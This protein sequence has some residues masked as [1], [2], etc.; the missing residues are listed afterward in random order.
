MK[1]QIV[2]LLIALF[3][4][5]YDIYSYLNYKKDL[6]KQY[7]MIHLGDEDTGAKKYVDLNQKLTFVGTTICAIFFLLKGLRL[8]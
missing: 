2:Y 3:L 6:E 1:N 7:K 5:V 4:I 8:I